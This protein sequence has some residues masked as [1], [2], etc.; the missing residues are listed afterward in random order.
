MLQIFGNVYHVT[1]LVTWICEVK[2]EHTVPPSPGDVC[3][4]LPSWELTSTNIELHKFTRMQ[5]R[6]KVGSGGGDLTSV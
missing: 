1:L 2:G 6:Q 3:V 4:R 5:V